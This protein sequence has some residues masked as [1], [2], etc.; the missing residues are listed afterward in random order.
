MKYR[1]FFYICFFGN[2]VFTVTS[3]GSILVCKAVVKC[4]AQH[5]QLTDRSAQSILSPRLVRPQRAV[6]PKVKALVNKVVHDHV[7]AVGVEV[8]HG[9]NPLVNGI[10]ELLA[11][12]PTGSAGLIYR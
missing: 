2:S 6:W 7:F 1:F 10:S 12:A 8:Q 9:R 4:Q 3:P 5:G 11:P